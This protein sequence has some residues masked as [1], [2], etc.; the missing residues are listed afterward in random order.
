M[1][2]RTGVFGAVLV[3]V[4]MIA[5]VAV[6]GHLQPSTT[7]TQQLVVFS[8]G[9]D[10]P[11]DG[12]SHLT[13]TS[14]M[15]TV[16]VEAV[17]LV[18][19]DVH[20]LWWVVFNNPAGCSDPCGENDIF[21]ENGLFAEGIAAADIAIGNATGNVAKA[22]GTIELGGVLKGGD[23]GDH[24]VLFVPSDFGG[25]GDNL[26]NVRPNDAEFHVIV[27][28]HGNARGGKQLLNQLST[29]EFGCTPGCEDIL[30]AVHLP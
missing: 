13:R 17:N 25:T 5:G 19:G 8:T 2:S 28:S 20:T 30:A 10:A 26:L 21:D 15:A 1:K 29:V 16:V 4:M 14:G 23:D 11:G 22:D 27:Q 24:Q 6:A 18:P 9:A 12:V 3:A 7:D